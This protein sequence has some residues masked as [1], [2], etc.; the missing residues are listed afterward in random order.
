[1]GRCQT[2][3]NQKSTL[4]NFGGGGRNHELTPGGEI[5]NRSETTAGKTTAE[6]P[7]DSDGG[8]RSADLKKLMGVGTTK[9]KDWIKRCCRAE[10][11]DPLGGR[12]RDKRPC[13]VCVTERKCVKIKVSSGR[14]VWRVLK[15]T[16]TIICDKTDSL[17]TLT[18]SSSEFVNTF[19]STCVAKK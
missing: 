9:T 6:T 16:D 11:A 1:M 19:E 15:I 5:S 3:A 12:L 10:A 2:N 4:L 14:R 8:R 18:V 17:I 7:H 13:C